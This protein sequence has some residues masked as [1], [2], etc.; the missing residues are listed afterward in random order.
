M[1][2]LGDMLQYLKYTKTCTKYAK[3]AR[4]NTTTPSVNPAFEGV[5]EDPHVCSLTFAGITT[6]RDTNSNKHWQQHMET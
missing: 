4:T 2:A 5:R 6:H 3:L 1:E